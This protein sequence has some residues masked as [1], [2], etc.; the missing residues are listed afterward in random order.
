MKDTNLSIS[1]F[2]SGSG[3]NLSLSVEFSYKKLGYSIQYLQKSSLPYAP[4]NVMPAEG[5]GGGG[6]VGGEA[7]PRVG[8]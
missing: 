6:G 2:M 8:I 4:I 7:G 3:I 5:G 1:P